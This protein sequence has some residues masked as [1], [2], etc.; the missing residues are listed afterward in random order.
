MSQSRL[1]RIA[2]GLELPVALLALL[3][4]PALV[5]EERA[6]R[7]GAH[8]IGVALNWIVWLAFCVEFGLRWSA[9]RTLSFPRRAWFDL[10]LIVVSP[11]FGV[12]TALQ[13]ARSLRI[14]RLLRLVRAFG[15]AG[16]A[17]RLAQGHFSRR[18]FHYVVLVAFAT[19]L[20]GAIGIYVVED[21][22]NPA[23][24][25]FGDALWWGM[26][27][28]TTVGYGDVSPVTLEGRLIAIVLML[29]G[30]GVIGVFTATVASFF[31]EA[32]HEQTAEVSARLTAIEAKVDQILRRLDTTI[33]LEGDAVTL[34]ARGA[35]VQQEVHNGES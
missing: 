8:T 7:P 26:V 29:T 3:V 13:G 25:T 14:L 22:V 15:V 30:I 35:E 20:L 19:V 5:L 11:P 18:K 28:V 4:I 34:L 12:P 33:R 10:L 16:I 32:Q 17:L 9:D 31:V 6:F 27:T 24:H 21:G 1:Q 2:K 23:I